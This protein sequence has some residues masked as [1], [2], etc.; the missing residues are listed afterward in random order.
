LAENHLSIGLLPDAFCV[1]TE[2]DDGKR[3][4]KTV[5]AEFKSVLTKSIS[6]L[7]KFKPVLV[8]IS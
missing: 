3:I 7:L 5:L 6:E 4:P 1:P 8:L 2:S